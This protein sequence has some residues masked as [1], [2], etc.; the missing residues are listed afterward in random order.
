MLSVQHINKQKWDAKPQN[1][2]EVDKVERKS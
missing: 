2:N 1:K